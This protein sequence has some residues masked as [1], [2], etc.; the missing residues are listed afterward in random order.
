M[1][2]IVI[3]LPL[4]VFILYE[5]SNVPFAPY[6]WDLVH[7][8]EWGNISLVPTGGAV[9][10]DRWIQIGN[11]FLVFL[12]FGIGED[13][14]I[15]YREWLLKAGFG[16]IFPTL[17]RENRTARNQSH[18]TSSQASS[19]GS[20]ARLFFAEK[21]STTSVH[22]HRSSSPK[23][24]KAVTLTSR[25]HSNDHHSRASAPTQSFT[26][27]QRALRRPSTDTTNYNR[28]SDSTATLTR[29]SS[30]YLHHPEPARDQ[31]SWLTQ[32]HIN[33]HIAALSRQASANSAQTTAAHQDGDVVLEMHDNN[34]G[35][36]SKG[37][38]A[39]HTT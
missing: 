18:S 34:H 17:R 22:P 32:F 25:R 39:G 8:P 10:F 33:S 23:V 20:R 5:N 14:M 15:M 21:F 19:M 29:L 37:A 3:A 27:P 36:R 9:T 31:L 7:G 26:E 1:A 38:V 30:E 12:A 24:S 11:G 4:E 16:R 28:V 6:S 2:L 35:Q 13:A